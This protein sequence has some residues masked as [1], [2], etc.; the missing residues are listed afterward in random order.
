MD[1]K[2]EIEKWLKETG[3][4]KLHP[5]E[6]GELDWAINIGSELS[7][8]E[9]EKVEAAMLILANYRLTIAHL[10]GLCFARVKYFESTGGRDQ[11]MGQRA[12]LN[13]IKPWHDAIEAK[14]AVV[15]KVHDRKVREVINA[16]SSRR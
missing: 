8:L 6:T 14:I 2:I 10:M 7:T 13:I 4:D 16:P 12:K 1:L 11:L 9:V 5:Y 3:V 15:K